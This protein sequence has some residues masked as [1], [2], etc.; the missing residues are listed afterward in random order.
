MPQ[1]VKGDPFYLCLLDEVGE[2][3]LTEIVALERQA[4]IS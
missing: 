1:S 4:R 2:L 3:A